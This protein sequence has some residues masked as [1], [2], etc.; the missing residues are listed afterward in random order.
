VEVDWRGYYGGEV[1]R[2]EPLPTYPFERQRYWIETRKNARAA[3]TAEQK[4]GPEDWFYAPAWKQSA[5][6]LPPRLGELAAERQ[7]WL[8]F[9][10]EQDGFGAALAKRLREEGQD[11]FLVTP[12]ERFTALGERRFALAPEDRAGF[13]ALLGE[14]RGRGQTPHRV[15]HLWSLYGG[16]EAREDFD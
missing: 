15:V 12:A 11:V 3:A 13:D 9:A 1:R 8:L 14:L 4:R 6:P 2:R 10:H 7:R 16:A 5:T